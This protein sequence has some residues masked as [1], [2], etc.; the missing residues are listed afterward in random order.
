MG[1]GGSI[2]I[3]FDWEIAFATRSVPSKVHCD[4][5]RPMTPPAHQSP[6]VSVV[7]PNLNTVAYL[8]ER[9]RSIEAQTLGNLQVIVVDSHSDDGSWELLVA[10]AS[11][12]ARVRLAQ[13][14]RGLYAAWNLGLSLA[15][16]DWIYVATSD[17]T[18]KDDC[19]E[20]LLATGLI[21][22]AD[23]VTSKEWL[24]D[25]WGCELP[26]YRTRFGEKLLGRSSSA[27]APLSGRREILFALL[28][29][30]PTT[31][32]TQMLIHRGVFTRIGNFSTS[33]SSYGDFHWQMKALRHSK[34]VFVPER[35]GAWR[36]H[37]AQATPQSKERIHQ[38]RAEIA[39]ALWREG[40]LWDEPA[41]RL[42][43]GYACGVAGC[44][45][46]GELP[47]IARLIAGAVR[48]FP[49]RGRPRILYLLSPVVQLLDWLRLARWM[50]VFVA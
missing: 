14:P 27:I 38:A 24:I 35:L 2:V 12:D 18:M 11:R 22:N 45:I 36:I 29:G 50:P 37:S 15:R 8:P 17:D 33:F 25:R 39:L 21:F 41:F 40:H 5:I 28:F 7:L 10:W 9:I 4:L 31:S 3:N 46:A 1:C 13:A 47:A 16:A 44:K 6:E 48:R 23:V 49:A 30:T 43:L 32:V 34:W 20:V 42:A 26:V 19:L